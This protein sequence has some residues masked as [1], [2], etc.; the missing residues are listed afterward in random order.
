MW[1]ALYLSA[2]KTAFV[3]PALQIGMLSDDANTDPLNP[4]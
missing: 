1:E 3:V 2:L 4:L